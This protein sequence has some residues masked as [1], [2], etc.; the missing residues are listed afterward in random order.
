MNKIKSPSSY[1]LGIIKSW[2][3]LKTGYKAVQKL[4]VEPETPVDPRKLFAIASNS[5]SW[6][7]KSIDRS[8]RLRKLFAEVKC[9]HA[10]KLHGKILMSLFS[11]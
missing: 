3:A 6:L 8:A 11:L 9:H 4:G 5:K 10:G 2:A 7:H 1:T